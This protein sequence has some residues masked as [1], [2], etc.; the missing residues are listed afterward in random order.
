MRTAK[1]I[2][3]L[4]LPRHLH[5]FDYSIPDEFSDTVT[6][7]R[8]VSIP[9]RS[10]HI[11]GLVTAITESQGKK[12]KSIE[13]VLPLTYE[14]FSKQY[15]FISWFAD[16]YYV[17]RA[18]ALKT[19]LP[20]FPRSFLS[21]KKLR[22]AKNLS[23][24]LHE[25]RFPNNE[26]STPTQTQ[27]LSNTFPAIISP[28]TLQKKIALYTTFIQQSFARGKNILI[29]FPT[30][31]DVDL[32]HPIATQC[33]GSDHTIL[34]YSALSEGVLFREWSKLFEKQTPSC[35]IG[36][37]SA[38]C[39]PLSSIDTVIIDQSERDEHIQYD[40]N[41]R[42]DCRRIAHA[43]THISNGHTFFSSSAPRIEDSYVY[44]RIP[45][46]PPQKP[47]SDPIIINLHD[48]FHA[49]TTDMVTERLRNEIQN[50]L[51][52]GRSA[53]LYCNHVGLGRLAVCHE[54]G[55]T[56]SCV[57]CGSPLKPYDNPPL[58]HCPDC[59]RSKPMSIRCPHCASVRIKI[60]GLG[61]QKIIH[62]LKTYFPDVPILEISSAQSESPVVSALHTREGRQTLATQGAIYVGTSYSLSA[63]PELFSDVGMIGIIHTDPILSIKNFRST[64]R[65]WQTLCALMYFARSFESVFCLQAFDPSSEFIQ[66]LARN[67]YESF[68]DTEN[69]QRKKFC[70]PPYSRIVHLLYRPN[71]TVTTGER[72]AQINDILGYFSSPI[73]DARCT[74]LFHGPSSKAGKSTVY[75]IGLKITRSDLMEDIPPTLHTYLS[76]LPND[77]LV[78]IEP[79]S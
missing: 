23:P 20:T 61:T 70:W 11:A 38:L 36:T 7:G 24:R 13:R 42:F 75:T 35:I 56:F 71:P 34:L 55:Y 37:R 22:L 16:T 53:F 18:T 78:D 28:D 66:T 29:L 26:S 33:T 50:A 1:V 6:P 27:I 43:L 4:R 63:C 3:I 25:Y 69:T 44:P 39:A 32:F 73:K 30:I 49:G 9:F 21:G 14:Q 76:E 15:D 65:R 45:L 68:S 12:I 17:S 52:C 8:F 59:A 40:M 77:W 41:P 72:Q 46:S 64:E 74:M 58:L 31:H 48:E 60:V 79:L 10:M 2:P 67:D 5:E 57:D 47:I 19:L 54:C 62:A 51:H